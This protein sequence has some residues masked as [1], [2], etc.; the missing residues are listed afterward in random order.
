MKRW[1]KTN[2]FIVF[3]LFITGIVF[4]VSLVTVA[5]PATPTPSDGYEPDDTPEEAKRVLISTS[6]SKVS[7]QKHSFH[8]PTDIDWVFFYG[9][10]GQRYT[11]M[12]TDDSGETINVRLSLQDTNNPD[13]PNNSNN[14][15]D[16]N[17][18]NNS[19][20]TW[21]PI[22]SSGS[23]SFNCIK[24][25]YYY[26]KIEQPSNHGGDPNY[27]LKVSVEQAAEYAAILGRVVNRNGEGVNGI[28][29]EFAPFQGNNPPPPAL[30]GSL[31]KVK[32]ERNLKDNILD[33]TMSEGWY[34]AVAS[35]SVFY[36][37]KLASKDAPQTVLKRIRNII[38]KSNQVNHIN[39]I[40]LDIQGNEQDAVS[41]YERVYT[42][43]GGKYYPPDGDNDGDGLYNMEE[44]LFWTNQDPDKPPTFKCF[45]Y[46]GWN[47]F[48]FSSL[49]IY[50]DVLNYFCPT[51]LEEGDSIWEYNKG[52]SKWNGIAKSKGKCEESDK[53]SDFN[54]M[55]CNAYLF[56]YENHHKVIPQI[57]LQDELKCLEPDLIPGLNLIPGF[58]LIASSVPEGQ[59][60]GYQGQKEEYTSL[61]YLQK[62]KSKNVQSISRYKPKNGKWDSTCWFFGQPEGNF[63]ILPSEAYITMKGK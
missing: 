5:A 8:S 17:N 10:D 56:Y 46:R 48:P 61:E 36:D 31:K 1:V 63:S 51:N 54:L 9:H 50:Y 39:D 16:S 15:N 24:D 30:T 60:G 44:F 29:V 4:F 52:S 33:Q 40:V 42:N 14:S 41:G 53:G 59:R 32:G 38:L 55:S 26:L 7:P 23:L 11:M 47:L 21:V 58:S 2:A 13:N 3:V 18:S 37:L 57:I 43:F 22:Q 12:A 45:L 34:F 27:N 28:R 6:G 25:S 35:V 49:D 19:N 20:N 62:S